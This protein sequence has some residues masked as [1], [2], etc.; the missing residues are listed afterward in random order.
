MASRKLKIMTAS[1]G[2]HDA[3]GLELCDE[4]KMD[5]MH[6]FFNRPLKRLEWD[7]IL[8]A[9]EHAVSRDS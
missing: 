5:E 8:R 3:K 7:G 9:V 4:D 6:L 2:V 1:P